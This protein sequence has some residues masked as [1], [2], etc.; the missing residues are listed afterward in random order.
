MTSAP[1]LAVNIDRGAQQAAF[2]IAFGVTACFT[3]VEALDWDFT[4]IAPM[5]AA[6]MLV[7]QR[8]PPK[9]AQGLALLL[10]I[11][12]ASGTLLLISTAFVDRPPVLILALALV[13]Y[14][15]FYAHLRGKPP[16]V[17]LMFQISAVT[18]PVFA[19]ISPELSATLAATLVGSGLVALL[20]VWAAH[21]AFPTPDDGSAPD[22]NREGPPSL[23]ARVAA[24]YAL[25]NMLILMPVL[26][27]YLVDEEQVA[28]V[29]LIVIVN[30]I[31]LHDPGQGQRAA[32]G[33][34]VGNLIG[35]FAAALA[36]ALIQ[37]HDTLPFFVI[38]CLAASLLFAG[39]IVTAGPHAPLY[40]IAFTAF[41]ILLATGITP[42]PGGSGEAFVSRI[43]NVLLAAAYAI[44][45][46][47]LFRNSQDRPA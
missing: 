41:L 44:G 10:V 11:G 34:I 26:I 2:R 1:T 22:G 33:L 18:L 35:G 36:Y 7:N 12:L 43:F 31:R 8:Q 40:T 24:R 20:T 4:F 39:R 45:A 19:V 16:I 28:I 46:L 5:L 47:S 14:L 6:Q 38:V 13:L 27:W 15:S 25:H 37:A 29:L 9:I 23:P 3:I 42:L 21:A 17:T 30:V 32:I